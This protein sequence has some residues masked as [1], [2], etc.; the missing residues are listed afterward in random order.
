LR[1]SFYEKVTFLA[2]GVFFP[3]DCEGDQW[4]RLSFT[5]QPEELIWEGIKRLSN[6][7]KRLEKKSKARIM[8][9]KSLARPI[10]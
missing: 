10:V 3:E 7:L 9:E 5:Y 1:E 6:A 2:G 4:L 8:P